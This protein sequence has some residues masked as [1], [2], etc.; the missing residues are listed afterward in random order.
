M[1]EHATRPER[2][3]DYRILDLIGRGGMGVVYAATHEPSGASAAV[4]TVRVPTES[5]LESLRREIHALSGLHHPGVVRIREHGVADGMP[6]YAMDLLRGRTLRDWLRSWWGDPTEPRSDTRNLRGPMLPTPTRGD[7]AGTDERDEGVAPDERGVP[8]DWRRP[9]RGPAPPPFSLPTCLGLFQA[10]C[11]PLAFLHGEGLVH[12]DLSPSN[13]F[14]CSAT[15][16]DPPRPMLFDFGLAA[17]FRTDTA[18]DVL[19]VGGQAVGTTHYMAPEQARGEVVDARADVYALGCV[20][21][22][23]LTGRPPYVGDT[24]AAV[25]WQHVEDRPAPPSTYNPALPPALDEL[26]LHMLARHARDRIGYL[27]DVARALTAL[28]A[29][30]LTAPAPDAPPA[31]S[32]TYRPGVCGRGDWLERFDVLLGH[33]ERG[34]GGCVFLHGESGVGK[35]RLAAEVATRAAARGL[36]VVPG[37]CKAVV[38][39][40]GAD[41]IHGAPLHPLRGL[42]QSVA[43]RAR[44]GGPDE[45]HR[46]LGAGGGLLAAYEP[47]LADVA[48]VEP[49]D[50]ALSPTGSRFRVL[51]LLRD[52]LIAFAGG[53]PVMLVLDDLQW[54]DELTLA[55]L[56]SLGR[57][58]FE[59]HG[60]LLLATVR[61]EE[62]TAAH[63]GLVRTLGG[64]RFDLGRLARPAV[65]EMIRDMLALEADAPQLTDFVAAQSEGN[66]F[67]A[68]EYLRVAVDEGVLRRD[69]AGRWRLPAADESGYDRLPTPGSIRELVQRRLAGLSPLARAV[70]AAAAVLGRACDVDVLGATTG[71]SELDARGGLVELQ[72]RHIVDEAGANA[73]RFEHDKLR[74]I[75]YADLD[76][77]TRRA[78]HRRAAEAL[79]ARRGGDADF[80]LLMP[81]LAH[82][83]EAAGALPDARDA[84][85]RAAQHA[86]DHAAYGDAAA[87]LRRLL[88]LPLPSAAARRARWERHLGEACYGLG[89]LPACATHTRR[90]LDGLGVRLPTTRGGWARAIALA[91]ARQTAAR[92]RDRLGRGGARTL[93]PATSG[94]EPEQVAEAAMAAARMTSCYFFED[95]ALAMIGAALVSVNLAE[96]ARHQ[97]PVAEP[98]AQIGYVAGLGRLPGLA[99]AYHDRARA[100]ARVTADPLGLIKAHCSHAAWC[101]GTGAWG[102]AR[103]QAQAALALAQALRNP[104]EIEV[105]ETI[106]GHVDWCQG[107]WDEARRRAALLAASARK[108]G[109]V[110]HT[111]WGVYTLGRVD[112]A[113]GQLE[114]ARAHFAE[115]EALLATQADHASSVLCGGMSA[116]AWARHGDAARARAAADATT[117]RIGTSV[118]AVFTIAEGFTGA[119]EAYLELWEDAGAAA[120]A[121]GDLPAR[122]RRAI[123][124]ARRFARVFPIASPAVHVLQARAARLDRAPRQAAAAAR[125]GLAAATALGLPLDQAAAHHELARLDGADG[126]AHAAAARALWQ[127]LGCAWQLARPR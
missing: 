84:L 104:Q 38:A 95:D 2:I 47:A 126:A 114:R 41:E 100:T 42:L 40:G 94:D 110:Q 125:K 55:L 59:E 27:D 101:V 79:V 3:G 90:S 17:H 63:D 73:V 6:W 127:Q 53:E 23:A 85:E 33:L 18:R 115:A 13:V 111:A 78:L 22:E 39:G 65:G 119:A 96:R 112:L 44:E 20:L 80:V 122:A 19:E 54:A 60:I 89:D 46:L 32:Y 91:A 102:E 57:A 77:G 118:P 21:Y 49:G 82:H 52:V 70:A 120:A 66:P 1:L 11:E 36:R 7:S 31:R 58:F 74:E 50:T 67:F 92:L 28:G 29:V 75:A 108:R 124:N 9:L 83:W 45:A 5:S 76:A 113:Q 25:L 69:L 26:V 62:A 35:T 121:A 14:L 72:L 56:R 98:Y 43:D 123:G 71:L 106:L 109:N 97:V 87:H 93:P 61:G 99:R 116:L 15:D 24:R 12:R 105:C 81:E 103:A 64:V 34:A 88:A 48:P 4:K 10:L 86:L 107:R 16:V 8:R 37:E 117:A 51:A 30:P 68:A